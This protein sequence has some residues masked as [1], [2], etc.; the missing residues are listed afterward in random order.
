MSEGPRG[1]GPGE[2]APRGSRV[3]LAALTLLAACSDG[4]ASSPGETGG[5]STA[6]SGDATAI[7]R[8]EPRVAELLLPCPPEQSRFYDRDTAD[9]VAI[10]IDK[11]SN[12]QQEPLRRAKEELGAMGARSVDALRRVIER[13]STEVFLAPY[14]QNAIEAA[15]MNSDP[16]VREFLLRAIDHPQ[17]GI[18][19]AALRS[20]LSRHVRPEDFDRLLAHVQAFEPHAMQRAFVVGL[21]DADRERAEDLV[22]D[23][24]ESGTNESL[25][26]N[27]LPLFAEARRPE[28]GRAAGE[29]LERVGSFQRPFLAAAAARAGSEEALAY[30]LELLENRDPNARTRAVQALVSAGRAE[31]LVTPMR[32][33]ENVNVRVLAVEGL[34]TI[35]GWN[36]QR[37]DWLMEAVSDISAQV[38]SQALALL[39]AKGD[40]QAIDFAIEYLALEVDLVQA[41]LNALKE[42]VRADPALASRM[43]EAL[44]R[45]YENER[46]RPLQDRAATLKALGIVP[47]AEAAAF[48]HEVGVEAGLDRI[49]GLRAHEW[50]MIQAAN[51]GQPGLEWMCAELAREADPRRRIDLFWAIGTHRNETAREALLEVAEGTAHSPYEVLFVAGRLVKIGPTEV[52]APR[53]KR[54]SYTLEGDVRRALQCLLW[55]WY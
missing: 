14:A 2:G 4:G 12:G 47:L 23:W 50:L 44:M 51:T 29:L 7:Y 9:P 36:E 24:I 38:R 31:D 8:S 17:E 34:A 55:R 43:F 54:V 5:A 28:V 37:R 41:A 20:L 45:R 10:L 40:A 22:L 32:Q 16:E 42:P 1:N 52:L 15:G 30:L 48:L 39:V 27:V 11:L 21:F 46:H 26:I 3:G 49:E 18:R 53:L 19:R 13:N 35:D 33:D 6:G 25:W